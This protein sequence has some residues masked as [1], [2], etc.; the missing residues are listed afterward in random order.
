MITGW[1]RENPLFYTPLFFMAFPIL[2]LIYFDYPIWTL[3]ITLLFLATYLFLVHEKPSR[4]SHLIWLYM[5]GYIAYMTLFVNAGMIWFLFYLNSLF[6]Y[7]FKDSLNSFRFWTYLVT[8]LLMILSV[9]LLS[10]DI[11]FRAMVLI[12]PFINSSMLIFMTNERQKVEAK[13]VLQEKNKSINLLLAENER[14]RIGQ[15]LHDTL[16]HV[17]VMMSV[18]AELVQTLLERKDIEK[19]QKEVADLQAISQTAMSEVRQMVT[20]LKEHKINQELLIIQNIMELAG[21][22]LTIKGAKEC[23]VL[24]D[25]LQTKISMILRELTNNLLKHS[26]ADQCLLQFIN[27]K[28]RFQLVYQD[29]GQGFLEPYHHDLH[30]IKDRLVLIKGN[31]SITSYKNPTQIDVTIPL[32]DI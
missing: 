5:L 7:K 25:H 20:N 18:K 2:G 27:E 1:K 31:L 29:N 6:V 12:A 17:F 22:E 15:D 10:N 8:E 16:G 9:F 13:E 30:S 21:I 26:H 32:K 4:L 11:S 14:N 3:S 23:N 24:P 19:A 28:D